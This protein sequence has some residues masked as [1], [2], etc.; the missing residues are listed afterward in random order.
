MRS[1]IFLLLAT[2]ALA[3]CAS[4]SRREGSSIDPAFRTE[5]E[6]TARAQVVAAPSPKPDPAA[7]NPDFPGGQRLA[8]EAVQELDLERDAPTDATL[9]T[10]LAP[11][12]ARATILAGLRRDSTTF[13][14][15]DRYVTDKGLTLRL[16]VRLYLGG[17]K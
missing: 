9:V 14:A 7:I 13:P 15:A 3:G 4:I 6:A 5:P 10:V 8:I 16:G 1:R 12:G 11:A 2:A 17:G